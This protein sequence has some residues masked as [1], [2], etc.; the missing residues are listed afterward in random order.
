MLRGGAL[1]VTA[2]GRKPAWPEGVETLS[3]PDGRGRVDLA[4]L[5][6]ALGR[7]QINELH[8]EAG[9]RLNAALLEAG[10]VDELLVYL[11]PSL[12]GDPACGIVGWRE[13]LRTLDARVALDFDDVERV[14]ADLRIRALVQRK[15]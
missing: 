6:H 2:D 15:D 3:L 5:M 11:A 9:A 8:V 14:G 10:V 12:V 4:A 7:R 13:A 1:V